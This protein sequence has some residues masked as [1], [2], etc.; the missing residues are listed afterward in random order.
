[1]KDVEDD[2]DDEEAVADELGRWFTGLVATHQ[3]T[4][5]SLRQE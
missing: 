4:P 3:F 5:L 2:E 1:M